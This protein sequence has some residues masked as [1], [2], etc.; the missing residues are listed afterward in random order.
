[1]RSLFVIF[2]LDMSSNVSVGILGMEIMLF[3]SQLHSF[4]V[5]IF[6]GRIKWVSIDALMRLSVVNVFMW[7][8]FVIILLFIVLYSIVMVWSWS[9]NGL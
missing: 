7:L 3:M 4:N 5:V 2:V 6:G 8:M 9:L 1:M